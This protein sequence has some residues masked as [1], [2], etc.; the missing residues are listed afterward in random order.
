[1]SVGGRWW[2]WSCLAAQVGA[3]QSFSTSLVQETSG[4]VKRVSRAGGAGVLEVQFLEFLSRVMGGN[5]VIL[6]EG[7]AVMRA[8]EGL[9][10]RWLG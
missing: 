4:G 1:M 6:A 10:G 2:D 9:S 5:D 8:M 7:A 3:G